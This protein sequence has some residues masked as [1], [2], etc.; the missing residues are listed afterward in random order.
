[1][2]LARVAVAGWAAVSLGVGAA[3]TGCGHHG[4]SPWD[5]PPS[6]PVTFS[7]PTSSS[8]S[9]IASS[10]GP[11]PV[12]TPPPGQPTDYS[13]LL[14]KPG[15]I[16]SDFNT[17]QPPV[18][19]P[20]NAAGVAQLFANGDNS[21]RIG[22]T[23]MVVADPASAAAALENTKT[24]YAGKVN[25]TWQPADVGSNGTTISGSAPNDSKAV[26]VLLFTEGRTL[27]NLEFDSAANDPID[28]PVALDI[29]RKQDAAV[30]NGLPG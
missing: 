24:N 13:S 28:A 6:S 15:D 19:L 8:P 21:R 3:T 20:N 5:R 30:K 2:E 9:S 11:N 17:P 14:I 18:L 26:T 1:M 23:I 16:G 27:V 25:G 22:I 10:I 7:S 4:S 29:G 12:P